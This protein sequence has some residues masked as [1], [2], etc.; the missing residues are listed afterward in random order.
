MDSVLDPVKEVS[1]V[2]IVDPE[3]GVPF[4]D[5]EEDNEQI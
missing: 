3:Q 1:M 5:R 4:P 2:Q